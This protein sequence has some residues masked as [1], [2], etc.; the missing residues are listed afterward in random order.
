MLDECSA[1]GVCKSCII[2]GK[3]QT[4]LVEISSK[5]TWDM[6]IKMATKIVE[7]NS[8]PL[9]E[10]KQ[11]IIENLTLKNTTLELQLE[12]QNELD[13]KEQEATE[14]NDNKHP[15]DAFI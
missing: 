14:S 5:F 11:K 1:K 15:I 4:E 8:H 7:T 9:I 3:M 2:N 13:N 12:K 10:E 6:L